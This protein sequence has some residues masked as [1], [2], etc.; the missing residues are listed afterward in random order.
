MKF[1]STVAQSFRSIFGNPVRSGLTVLGIVIGI[2]AVIA[3]VGLG[4]GLQQSVA[5]SLSSLNAKQITV[6]SQDPTR[7][8]SE[9]SGGFGGGAG[10]GD[11]GGP[12]AAAAG[13][14][15]AGGASAAPSASASSSTGASG[16]GSSGNS[17]AGGGRFNFAATTPTVTAAD[18]AAIAALPGVAAVSP[19]A[20]K[21]LDVTTTA[22]ATTAAGYDV[23]GVGSSYAQIRNLTMA[24]GTWL[25]QEQ[26]SSAAAVAVL[27]SQ[28]A[29]TL[30]P[31][32]DAV[33]KQV[34]IANTPTTVV[35]VLAATAST[36]GPGPDPRNNPDQNVY[37]GYLYWSKL[38][39][40]TTYSGA[41]VDATSEDQVASVATAITTTLN[42]NHRIA[43][44]ANS[45]TRVTTAADILA[46]RTRITGSFT[47][48]LTGIAAVSLLV[49]GI[50]IMNIMLVTVTERTR[51]IGLRRAVGAKGRNI[52]AQFLSE[53]VILTLIGGVLGLGLGWLL[54][55][56]AGSLLTGVPGT[57]G[58]RGQTVQAVM[59]PQ[60][61][62]LAVG[63]A[64]AVGIIFGLFPAIRAARLD[65]A[66][67]LRYE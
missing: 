63:V 21:Q 60:V 1:G 23:F 31:N 64:V 46:A 47:T 8:V 54:G 18:V 37:T 27:G 38:T 2:A 51:E 10:G 59:D 25:T 39:G 41:L 45:D 29:S 67:A 55:R 13:G 61:A 35:G 28:A 9:R 44:G 5:G 65:P 11:G 56:A 48:A 3:M 50:G 53:S 57:G 7:P 22:N 43:A 12:P 52:L 14:G 6:N 66:G 15:G 32:G 24:S 16:Q 49:G 36:A 4:K 19:N 40:T 42:A 34:Y 30:F 33:G 26:V 62:L 17:G 20:S 58:P